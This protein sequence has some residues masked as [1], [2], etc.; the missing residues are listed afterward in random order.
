[1]PP[2][3]TE[4][5][6]LL[7]S[8]RSEAQDELRESLRGWDQPNRVFWV[9]QAELAASRA[10]SLSPQIIMID[11]NVGANP[12]RYVRQLGD[13]CP[14]ATVVM[15]VEP[16]RLELANRAVMAGARAVLPKPLL[17][18]SFELQQTLRQLLSAREAAG[19]AGAGEGVNGRIV[20]VVG[21]RG[22]VG[23]TS[24]ACNLAVC[25]AH[26]GHTS[27]ALL[28]ADF[29]A[30]AVDV[31]MNVPARRTI[32]EV[33]ERLGS[34]DTEL[35]DGILQTHSSGVRVMVTP[36]PGH[37][38]THPSTAHMERVLVLLRR[39]C[40]WTVIDL[41]H[42]LDEVAYSVTDVADVVLM[43]LPPEMAAVRNARAMIDQLH[44]RGY[45]Q[46]KVWMVLNRASATHGIPQSEIERRLLSVRH[47]I[48]DDPQLAL[49]SINRGVPVAMRHP[50]SALGRAYHGLSRKLLQ[51]Y[52]VA[53]LQGEE[54]PA[55]SG[56][57]SLFARSK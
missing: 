6:L 17:P 42:P 56:L 13:C 48:P 12:E 50:R 3:D 19:P 21:P 33:F 20:A 23:R 49:A 15:L 39:M 5:R 55:A 37:M 46:D 10:V 51:A 25:L 28:D 34:I 30:P 2:Q 47:A 27:V 31:M 14:M 35:L 26:D 53:Q 54:A 9:S 43:V 57:R 4:L 40:A 36:P 32:A 29:M 8:A 52:G 1:V 41:G 18:Q 16:D 11:D 38:E 22:G 44:S 7:V 24:V 45:G